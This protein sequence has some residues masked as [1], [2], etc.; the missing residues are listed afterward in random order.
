VGD[1]GRPDVRQSAPQGLEV[2]RLVGDHDLE[3]D[4]ERD[5]PLVPKR[6]E[7]LDVRRR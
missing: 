5:P 7:R 4:P 1:G 2:D 3:Q 6:V